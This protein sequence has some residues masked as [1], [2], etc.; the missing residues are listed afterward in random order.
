MVG[1]DWVSQFEVY[2]HYKMAR[3]AGVSEA[4]IANLRE[5]EG[6][7]GYALPDEI[8]HGISPGTRVRV[9]AGP[10]RGLSGV[11]SGYLRGGQ[12][13]EVLVQMLRS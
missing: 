9:M 8:V 13:A 2:A 11:F 6:D 3:D 5:R 10:F 7:R 1:V 4:M 12:R